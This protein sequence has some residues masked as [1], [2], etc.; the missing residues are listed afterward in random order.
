LTERSLTGK[1]RTRK[2]AKGKKYAKYVT[3]LGHVTDLVDATHE[4]KITLSMLYDKSVCTEA[5][6]RFESFI[7][8][9]PGACF[10]CGYTIV[11]RGKEH[12]E[13]P[14]KLAVEEQWIFLG[15]DPK[16]PTDLGGEL[17]CWVGEGEDAEKYTITKSSCLVFPAGLTHAPIYIRKVSRPFIFIAMCTAPTVKFEFVDKL[18]PG[19]SPR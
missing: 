14:V 10:S 8:Y 5:T 15:T 9:G 6:H 7:V 11:T 16:D 4:G 3:Q 19:F 12:R 17:D 2:M 13:M 1:R 18:P